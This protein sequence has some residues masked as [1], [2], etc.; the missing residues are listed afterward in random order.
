MVNLR[1]IVHHRYITTALIVILIALSVLCQ[2]L[3]YSAHRLTAARRASFTVNDLRDLS[4]ANPGDGV[5]DTTSGGGVCTLRA[6]IEE[7]NALAGA[8][9]INFS[10]SGTIVLSSPLPDI[11]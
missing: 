3:V 1:A 10:V 5:C 9:T 8:D 7:S 4:D 2:R 11:T 6:A